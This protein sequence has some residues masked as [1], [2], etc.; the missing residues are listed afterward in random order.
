MDKNVLEEST[1]IRIKRKTMKK[2][3]KRKKG[4]EKKAEWHKK[5]KEEVVKRII[6]IK[7]GIKKKNEKMEREKI[8][9]KQGKI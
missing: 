7:K 3:V 2:T 1:M 9:K 8:R 4:G 6:K 5:S